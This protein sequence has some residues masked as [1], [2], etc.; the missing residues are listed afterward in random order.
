[1][2]LH[3]EQMGEPRERMPVV[4]MVGR[5]GP[6]DGTA[7]QA[8]LDMR[9]IVDVVVVVVVDERMAERLTEDHR[10]AEQKQADDD[11]VLPPYPR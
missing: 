2:E 7:G 8:M 10:D 6:D 5:E 11:S 9:I 3:V 1:M 4:G